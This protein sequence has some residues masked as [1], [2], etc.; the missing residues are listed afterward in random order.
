MPVAQAQTWLRPFCKQGRRASGSGGGEDAD[1]TAVE[2]PMKQAPGS[3]VPSKRQVLPILLTLLSP[4]AM[5][6]AQM[7]VAWTGT[8]AAVD[9][10]SAPAFCS[11]RTVYA[12]HRINHLG[13]QWPH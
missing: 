2:A 9:S 13:R 5:C 6:A 8:I 11:S 12:M 10:A 4:A 1:L 7:P 3:K